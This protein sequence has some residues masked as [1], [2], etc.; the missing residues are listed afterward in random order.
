MDRD[1]AWQTRF[2]GGEPSLGDWAR[3]SSVLRVRNFDG[4]AGPEDGRWQVI[5]CLY[6]P[7]ESVPPQLTPADTELG[8]VHAG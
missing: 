4:V 3:A 1:R 5:L 8:A 2:P 7:R 6:F